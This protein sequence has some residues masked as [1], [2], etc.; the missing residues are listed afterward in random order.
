[1]HFLVAQ[2][3]I[4]FTRISSQDTSLPV[5]NVLN[6]SK[7]SRD[8]LVPVNEDD[9]NSADPGDTNRPTNKTSETSTI[10]KVIS[11]EER[12]S[13]SV[14]SNPL[15]PPNEGELLFILPSLALRIT[16]DQRQTMSQ[17]TL[18]SLPVVISGFSAGKES[19]LDNN[20]TSKDADQKKSP[21][22]F[23]KGQSLLRTKPFSKKDNSGELSMTCSNSAPSV[24]V[25]FQ[26]DFHG[27]IQLGLIDV[28]WLPS[29]ISSYLDERLND[30]ERE[31]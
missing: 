12:P 22:R 18:S 28:P 27:F 16:T 13:V 30:Y 26:T 25:S 23:S 4:C 19:T 6:S 21:G 7:P 8:M 11:K 20:V 29:L 31:F 10:N 24:K 14:R 3:P 9:G 5:F 15:K 2:F 1:M 17:P